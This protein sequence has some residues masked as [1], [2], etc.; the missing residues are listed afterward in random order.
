MPYTL[1][2]QEE[3]SPTLRLLSLEGWIGWGNEAEYAA[4]LPIP[5]QIIW[6]SGQS[7][8]Q[9]PI[10]D[11]QIEAIEQVRN[12][13][14]VVLKVSLGG[15]AA[16]PLRLIPSETGGAAASTARL[17]SVE[18]RPAPGDWLW[19]SEMPVQNSYPVS[20]N[21]ERERWLTV[22]QQFGAGTRRLVEL[23]E[24]RLPRDEQHWAEC[25]RLLD[26]AT[27]FYRGG[28]YEQALVNCRQ[29]V[30]GIPQVLCAVWGLPQKRNNQA[31]EGWMQ[32]LENRLSAAWQNDHLTPGML[33]TMIAG[34]WHWLA[35][36]PHY[37]TGIPLREDVAFALGLCTDLLLFAGQVLQAHPDPIA[38][39]P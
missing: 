20:F 12:G 25:V 18:A 37:G 28:E 24:P 2:G 6:P 36:T 11:T 32:E 8:L 9:V 35:P 29:I 19:I 34:A 39:G 1:P 14:P 4:K 15:L 27:Q 38:A 30:E 23:P 7:R 21:I 26:G 22:L 10:T 13:G 16:M 33:R 5:S 31:F 3:A 17:P